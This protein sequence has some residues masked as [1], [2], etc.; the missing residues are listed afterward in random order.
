MYLGRSL[1]LFKLSISIVRLLYNGLYYREARLLYSALASINLDILSVYTLALDLVV[2]TVLLKLETSKGTSSNDI[3]ART[4]I[5]L[6]RTYIFDI[7]TTILKIG[8]SL[9]LRLL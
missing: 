4:L 1:L 6:G 7:E 3:I 5:E 8:R 2:S 9:F